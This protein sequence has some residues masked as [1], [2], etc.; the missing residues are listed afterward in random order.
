MPNSL[1]DAID[2]L[3]SVDLAVSFY[4][5]QEKLPG[6]WADIGSGDPGGRIQAPHTILVIP[7]LTVDLEIPTIEQQA[8][9]ERFLFML[10]LLGQPNLRLVYV[11]SLAIKPEIVDYYLDMVPGSVYSNARKRLFLVSPEDGSSRPLSQ[12]LLERPWL[13]EHMRNMV[14]D[15]DNAHIV[16]FNTTDL[17]RELAVRLGVPMYAADPDFFAFGTKSGGRQIFEDEGVAHPLGEENL[18][19]EAALI[20]AIARLRARKPE[21]KKMIVKLNEGVAGLGN[22]VVDLSALDEPGAAAEE[23]GIAGCLRAMLFEDSAATHEAY[24]EA[25]RADGGIVEELV[26]GAQVQSP[27][28]QMR[29]TP[30]GEVQLLSTHDQI[31]GGPS[32]Q[33]FVGASFPA[34]PEYSGLITRDALKIGQ[35]L[36]REGVIGRYA[37]DFLLV[38]DDDSEQW[39]PYA[40]E[41]NLR[42]G[43]TTTPYLTLQYLTR[44]SYDAKAGVFRT[45]HGQDKYYV[46]NDH[47][48]DERFRMFTPDI[49]FDVLT[50]HRL[51]FNHANQVG[52]VPHMISC[53]G[54]NGSVGLTA[55][56]NSPA[57]AS[58]LYERFRVVLEE[59]AERRAENIQQ[60]TVNR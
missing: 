25:W 56:A 8:Y 48:R 22:A 19:S 18:D 11:T 36:A 4:R 6:M 40:I 57:E 58:A 45:L 38:R 21:I 47:L 54:T 55:I 30:L 31:L 43:G 23:A 33:S 42:K 46:A 32:G 16:P 3:C 59:E 26:E 17:E 28:V 60:I 14:P 44:G 39:R 34:N 35:R 7:S 50:N 27:S 20:S 51:H 1:T 9:E 24:M 49:L 13:I 12:K 29:N 41:I 15:I 37:V 53:I 10:F 52:V 2:Q 5:L